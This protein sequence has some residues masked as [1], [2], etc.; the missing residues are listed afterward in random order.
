MKDFKTA[1]AK[2]GGGDLDD[3]AIVRLLFDR[4][5]EGLVQLKS[6]YGRMGMS[7]ARNILHDEED[8]K[9]CVNDAL[10]AVWNTI[11]PQDP[12]HLC[13]YFLAVT[14]NLALKRYRDRKSPTIALEELSDILPSD[15]RVDDA[16]STKE[17]RELLEGWMRR[18]SKKDLYIFMRKYWYFER[19][20]DIAAALHISER[21]VYHRLTRLKKD[22]NTYLAENQVFVSTQR[23]S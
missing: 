20:D 12:A 19:I 13:A 10:L 11:P 17:L 5:E 9:E 22:L 23:R 6:K 21:T 18:Q 16:L 3:R 14:R 15:E 8:A 1:F 4:A 2:K 7:I